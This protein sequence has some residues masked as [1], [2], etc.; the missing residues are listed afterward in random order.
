MRLGRIPT[1]RNGAET[2][3]RNGTGRWFCQQ[4][5]QIWARLGTAA[6]S[7]PYGSQH[8][9]YHN[10]I[11][12]ERVPVPGFSVPRQER[13]EIRHCFK[14]HIFIDQFAPPLSLEITIRLSTLAG[15]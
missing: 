4:L 5:L 13:D 1:A 8:E 15:L 6:R 2:T 12:S 7:R 3:P 11:P 9:Y 10:K 14:G